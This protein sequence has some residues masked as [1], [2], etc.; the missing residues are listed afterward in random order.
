M[1]WVRCGP[2]GKRVVNKLTDVKLN[3]P[4]SCG[5]LKRRK[6]EH[7]PLYQRSRRHP[8]PMYRERLRLIQGDLC[9]WCDSR[10][11]GKIEVDHDHACCPPKPGATRVCDE[12]VRALVH[13]KCNSEI[14]VYE[15]GMRAGHIVTVSA[16]RQAYFSLRPFGIEG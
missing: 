1:V 2:C 3:N 9:F 8:A 16:E 15:R 13:S 12:C 5:C 11:A 4:K 6:G 10:L 7:N 14:G